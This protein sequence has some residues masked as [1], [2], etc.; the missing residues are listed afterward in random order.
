MNRELQHTFVTVKL[1]LEKSLLVEFERI[2]NANTVTERV[3]KPIMV[4]Q[5]LQ[6]YDTY[7]CTEYSRRPNSLNR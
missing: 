2:D 3:S 4:I 6:M 5:M 1:F 7:N